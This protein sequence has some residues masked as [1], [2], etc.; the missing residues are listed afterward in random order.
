MGD[1][2]RGLMRLVGDRLEPAKTKVFPFNLHAGA[3]ALLMTEGDAFA[4]T[5][6]L[7]TVRRL[8]ASA[9]EVA[10][11]NHRPSWR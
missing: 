9:L 1:P 4:E 10:L 6:D 2:T 11:R 3:D 5:R 7:K 8:D